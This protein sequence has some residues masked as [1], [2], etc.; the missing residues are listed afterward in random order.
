MRMLSFK[1]IAL[2]SS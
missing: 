2:I 1:D